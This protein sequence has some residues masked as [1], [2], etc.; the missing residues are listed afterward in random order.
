MYQTAIRNL[1]CTLNLSK[2]HRWSPELSTGSGIL[3]QWY[4]SGQQDRTGTPAK[5]R[6]CGVSIASSRFRS[7]AKSAFLLPSIQHLGHVISADEIQPSKEKVRTLLKYPTPTNVQQLRSFLG[8]V[9][10]Y[11]KFMSNFHARSTK[12]AVVE[13]SEVDFGKGTKENLHWSTGSGNVYKCTRTLWPTEG[14]YYYL[15]TLLYMEYEPLFLFDWKMKMRDQSH[16]HAEHH[17]HLKNLPI[18][19]KSLALLFSE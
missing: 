15:A 6:Q 1:L 11:R 3:H 14:I 10:Y 8:A 19:T 18:W 5:F 17:Q 2:G 16:S 12:Q 13:W 7:C 9:K 4:C